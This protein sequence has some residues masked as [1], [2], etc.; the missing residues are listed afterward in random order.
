MALWDRMPGHWIV[1]VAEGNHDARL[2]WTRAISD[3]THREFSDAQA[4]VVGKSWT[5]FTFDSTTASRQRG[6]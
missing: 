1:R 3:Y 6:P 2:F 4:I 5:V